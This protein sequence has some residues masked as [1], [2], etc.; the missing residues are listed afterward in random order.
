V[1]PS[2]TS[3]PTLV[4]TVDGVLVGAGDAGGHLVWRRPLVQWGPPAAHGPHAGGRTVS[5]FL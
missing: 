5:R 1:A 2:E 3:S 4:S